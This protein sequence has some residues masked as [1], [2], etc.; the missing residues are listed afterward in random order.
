M[1][2][3]LIPLWVGELVTVYGWMVLLGDHGVINHFLMTMGIKK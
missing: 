1:L 2:L 3:L